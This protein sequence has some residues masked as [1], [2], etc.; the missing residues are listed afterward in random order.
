MKELIIEMIDL[1]V[2][3]HDYDSI[4]QIKRLID[5][6]STTFN[7]PSDWRSIGEELANEYESGSWAYE[8][9]ALWNYSEV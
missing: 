3:R 4:I 7:A 8:E 1:A 6:M 9:L 5:T 2:S